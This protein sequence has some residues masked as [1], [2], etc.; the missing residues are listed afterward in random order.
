MMLTTEEVVNE[1]KSLTGFARQTSGGPAYIHPFG[2]D[3]VHRDEN[4]D[5]WYIMTAFV[6][7]LDRW[8]RKQCETNEEMCGIASSL[9]I[10]DRYPRYNVH[11]SLLTL[12][13]LK[14]N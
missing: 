3:E 14:W 10:Y 7:S 12:I 6:S 13:A 5:D 1:Y 4:G 8:L 2:V 11:G 9:R